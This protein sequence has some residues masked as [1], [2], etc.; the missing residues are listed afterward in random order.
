[1]FEERYVIEVDGKPETR[2][3]SF[4]EAY[5]YILGI[6]EAASGFGW[7]KAKVVGDDPRTFKLLI[8]RDRK[9]VERTIAVKPISQEVSVRG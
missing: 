9:V 6:I 4:Q 1:M 7:I 3:E 8:K 2:A 5:C